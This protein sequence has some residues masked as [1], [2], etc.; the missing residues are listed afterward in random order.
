MTDYVLEYCNDIL[1]G[2]INA[3][4][5]QEQACEREIADRKKSEN[6]N[7]PYYFDLKEAN[8][9]IKFISL[10]PKTDGTKLE[11]AGFQK[12]IVGSLAGWRRKDNH[13]RRFKDGYISMARKSG[14]TY[15]ASA[16]AIQALLL[17]KV[18]AKNRQVLFVSNALKQAKLGYNMMSSEIRQLQRESPFLRR[19]IDV[20]KKQ[21]TKL[22]DDSFA[23]A[24]AGKP[25]T[26][27]GFSS[28]G[29]ALIDEYWMQKDDSVLNSIKSG[30]IKEPNSLCAIC[31]TTGKF[32]HGAMKK[33][34]DHYTDVLNDKVQEDTTFIAIWELDDSKEVTNPDNWIKAN[35][36]LI[37]KEVSDVLK[38]KLQADL[39]SALQTKD[40]S[41]FIIKNMNCWLNSN[42]DSFISD[43]DWSNAIVKPKPDITGCKTYIG[44]DLSAT[45][46]L[47]SISWLCQLK[48]G[49]WFADSY[50]FVSTKTDI[51]TK[52]KRDGIN[53]EALEKAGECE[54]SRLDSGLVDYDLVYQFII[55]LIDDNNLSVQQV[56]FDPWQGSAIISRLEKHGDIPLFEVSQNEKTLSEPTKAFREAIISKKIVVAD[57]HLLRYAVQN[58]VLHYNSTGA[59][60]ID[61][62][63]NNQKIDPVAALIDAYTLLHM[64]EIEVNDEK[65][66]DYYKNYHF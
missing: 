66:D 1:S 6:D 61:K 42:D 37:N 23:I 30:Q 62:L 32:Q 53:Y 56:C 2:K 29:M 14:K 16:L 41:N 12:F 7:F 63:R 22:D 27:D 34:Y 24:V 38:P 35:P 17:E 19:A 54:L 4:K 48:N 60:R 64:K 28:S 26:L 58:A 59:I 13:Y 39:N 33:L 52:M 31:S 10:V 65:S 47:T 57:N 11:M 43:R 40:I 55:N 50:S 5:K 3:C 15:I 8:K 46:D 49:K 44:L 25:E 9:S 21:I 18:P 20:K 36:L 45:N 51:I